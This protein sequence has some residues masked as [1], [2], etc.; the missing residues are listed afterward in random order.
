M[1]NSKLKETGSFMLFL[2]TGSLSKQALYNAG[3]ENIKL[4]LS[5][6]KRE[7][8]RFIGGRAL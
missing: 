7:K 6:G 8:Q 4:E 3:F 2:C 5:L 1:G